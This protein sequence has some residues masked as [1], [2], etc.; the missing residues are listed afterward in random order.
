MRYTIFGLAIMLLFVAATDNFAQRGGGKGRN[1]SPN[2]RLEALDL[3]QEQQTK[4]DD[5]RNQH[6]NEVG[7]L[8]DDL[9]RLRID[10]RAA[11]RNSNVDRNAYL[12]IEKKMSDI[13]E[14]IA[15][16]GAEF[17]MDVLELLNDEQKEKFS[18]M[19]FG[20]GNRGMMGGDGRMH[21]RNFR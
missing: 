11:L 17:R 20:K 1:W 7:K 16:S 4:I 5:L 12:D 18:N 8:R 13:R 19:N 14:K 6:Q 21:R 9:D 3:T 15:L 10:K 2:C